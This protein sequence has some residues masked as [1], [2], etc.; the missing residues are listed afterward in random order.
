MEMPLF[1]ALFYYC[2]HF[3]VA[4]WSTQPRACVRARLLAVLTAVR[5]RGERRL[6]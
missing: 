3:C 5:A 2:G 6:P 1:Y 4:A